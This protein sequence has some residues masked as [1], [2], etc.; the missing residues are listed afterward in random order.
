[1]VT[2]MRARG[3]QGGFTAIEMMVV[4]AILFIIGAFAAPSMTKLIRTQ[5]VRGASYDL[6]SDLTYA[7]S[8]AI[9]RGHNILVSSGAANW[10]GG[11]TIRD[12]TSGEMLRTQGAMSTGF[13]INAD[14]ASLTFDRSGRTSATIRW[15]IT[16]TDANV[17]SSDQRCVRISPSGRPNT[18]SPPGP[19]P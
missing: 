3:T 1:V 14:A 12:T 4:V 17:Q 18:L 16:P 15:T 9:A 19:C 7:R 11:W 13:A 6:F 2:I 5:K 8:E 10:V